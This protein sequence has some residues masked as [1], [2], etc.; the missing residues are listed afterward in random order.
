MM[1]DG[2]FLA[3]D[4]ICLLV[5]MLLFLYL[6]QDLLLRSIK[7][8]NSMILRFLQF[9]N[10]DL[11]SVD[12]ANVFNGLIGFCACHSCSHHEGDCDFND[13]CQEGLRC[14]SNNCPGYF[15]FKVNTDCCYTAI[16]GDEDFC[17]IDKPC[18]VNEGDC[19]S[20]DECK[21]H[22]FCGSNNCPEYLGFLFSI[23][24]CEPKGDKTL[25]IIL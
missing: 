6:I 20:N 1:I 16:V 4:I 3:Q 12:C 17:T 15:G 8:M 10:V 18:E 5:L 14:G 2:L 19:D 13:Q 9:E 7:V 24:C 21:N 11:F 23:D 25:S 22:L